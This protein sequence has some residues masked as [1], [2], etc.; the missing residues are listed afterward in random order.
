[1]ADGEAQVE[2]R[3]RE[4]RWEPIGAM[5][6]QEELEEETQG[7]EEETEARIQSGHMELIDDLMTGD[8]DEDF[9]GDLMGSTPSRHVGAR[10]VNINL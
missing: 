1:M 9:I 10:V 3:P 8:E 2:P 7:W 5:M 6:G 4:R